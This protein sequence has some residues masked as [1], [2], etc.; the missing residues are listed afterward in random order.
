MADNVP[1]PPF[2]PLP[3]FAEPRAAGIARRIAAAAA[4]SGPAAALAAKGRDAT[5]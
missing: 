2:E 4:A 3:L 5:E 1:S